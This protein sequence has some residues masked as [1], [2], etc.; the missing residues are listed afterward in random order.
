MADWCGSGG[1]VWLLRDNLW[2]L[3]SLAQSLTTLY[4][5]WL[6]TLWIVMVIGSRVCLGTC[7]QVISSCTLPLFNL[8]GLREV[9]TVSFGQNQQMESSQSSLPIMLFPISPFM[10]EDQIWNKVWRWKGPQS[11]W[12]FLRLVMHIKL[13]MKNELTRR[14]IQLGEFCDR[15]GCPSEDTLLVIRDGM[16][17]KCF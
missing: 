11:I 14:H 4:T 2:F 6:L 9:M 15:H 16:V 1:I 10:P 13:K 12:I 17:A 3:M 8:L 5:R 7:F